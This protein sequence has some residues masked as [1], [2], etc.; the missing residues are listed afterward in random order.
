M[1]D[2]LGS[3]APF[4]FGGTLGLAS[5]AAIMIILG[6]STKKERAAQI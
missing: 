6:S 5:A 2:K 1:W 3:D 4:W